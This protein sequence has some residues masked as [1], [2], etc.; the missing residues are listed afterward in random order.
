MIVDFADQTVESTYGVGDP[1]DHVAG[2]MY[3]NTRNTA[4]VVAEASFGLTDSRIG[5]RRRPRA[6]HL[7]RDDPEQHR[8]V[9][10]SH[11][12]MGQRVGR[13][14][15]KITFGLESL[16]SVGPLEEFKYSMGFRTE[17]LRQRVVF[18]PA[19]RSLLGRR[20]MRAWIEKK[21]RAVGPSGTPWRKVV[22]LVQFAEAAGELGMSHARS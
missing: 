11:L 16:E 15:R 14:V 22:G 5:C 6:R 9:R 13:G 18:H 10:V 19:M 12:R 2:V 3:D 4:G 17:A 7:S 1:I 21:A 20:W 8:R